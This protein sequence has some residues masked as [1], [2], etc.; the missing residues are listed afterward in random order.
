MLK[1]LFSEKTKPH[2]SLEVINILRLIRSENVGPKTFFSLIKLFGDAATAIE[3]IKEF[4]LRG[5][6]SKAIKVFSK[7][8]A[9]KEIEL[10]EKNNAKIITY[11]SPDYSSLLLEIYDPPPILSYKGN[12][13]LLNYKQCIAIVGAR[14]AS[15]NGCAFASKIASELAST[16]YVTISGLA[17]GIDSAVHKAST[18]STIGVI[19]GGIDHI[20]PLENKSLFES[21]A[22]K[23]LIIAELPI[24]AT[25]LG[26]HFPQ[27]NRLI[28]GLSLGT[29]VIEASLK[30]GSLITAR[31][32]LEQGREL[33]AVPGFPLDPRCQGTNKLIKEGAHIVQSVK[34]IVTNLPQYEKFIKQDNNLLE[35]FIDVSAKFRKLE[36]NYIDQVTEKERKQITDLLSS[37]PLDFDYI[38]EATKLSLPAIYTVILELELAGRVER[39][40]GNRISLIYK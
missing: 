17:R 11:K 5:G 4:S 37:V 15:A 25:P 31:L 27:R 8:D 24:G 6:R 13:K 1:E 28:S 38:Q 7:D 32:A 21:L 10:L 30:S 29:V 19:A 16:N 23:G 40:F 14:N 20:Y 18:S 36:A 39:H 3:N 34:D 12:I 9:E 33:F 2:Y 35:D 22:E 26:Q